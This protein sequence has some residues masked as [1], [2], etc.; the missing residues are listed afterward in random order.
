MIFRTATVRDIPQIQIIRNSVKENQLSDP[1]LV[2]DK[3]CYE[4]IA[5]R[6]K[7]W[8]CEEN[9]EIVA[10]SIVDFKNHNIWALFVHPKFEK[11][12]IGRTLHDM[13]LNHY[14][15]KTKETV[16]LG[17]AQGTRA[18]IF[19]QNAGWKNIGV[20]GKNEIKFEMTFE[21]WYNLN[22]KLKHE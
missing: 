2:T 8:V 19:Y 4:Y 7:G 14:F 12:G 17:T 15:S 9:K 5:V 10:F 1:N 20:H 16:W 3:D 13:M 11:Q 22:S 21:T 6:G 18:Q